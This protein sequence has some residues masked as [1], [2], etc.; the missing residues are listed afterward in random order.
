[1][2]SVLYDAPGP[3]TRRRSLTVSIIVVLVVVAILAWAVLTLA[4][5]GVFDQE[6]W[7][8]FND[9]LVWLALLDGLWV[10]L[11]V[12]FYGAILAISLGI[13]LS[14]LRSSERRAVRI[15]TTVV[16][17]FLRGMPVLLMILFI[18]LLFSTGAFWAVVLALGLY[19]GAIIGEALRSGLESLPRGQRES[20]LAI[21]LSSIQSRLLIEFPQAFRTMLPIIVAQLVVL[22]KDTALG[23]IVGN[24][25]L[26]RRGRLLA[27]FF[28]A[29][30]YALSV[31][32][33]MLAMYLT[34]NLTISA[35]ARRLAKQ[36]GQ[37]LDVIQLKDA[38]SGSL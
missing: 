28:G 30:Q 24:I 8:I 32:F 26:I 35:I 27:E 33:V 1:V 3:K 15:P 36:R 7:D 21:G 29:G 22:L 14:L 9:P 5:Q 34:V 25:D 19:N 31:F 12:A 11:Q 16:L 17:E 4:A 10:T 2:T 20:G 18:L 37:K 6:R 13:V 38:G 23:Y